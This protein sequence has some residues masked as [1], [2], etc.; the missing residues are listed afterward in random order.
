MKEN[1]KYDGYAAEQNERTKGDW[2]VLE[3]KGFEANELGESTIDITV[4][5]FSN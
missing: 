1:H 3:P 5:E 2:E 4:S